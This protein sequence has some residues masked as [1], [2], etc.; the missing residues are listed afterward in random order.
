MWFDDVH[1][2]FPYADVVAV[3]ERARTL[4]LIDESHMPPQ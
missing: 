4:L 3:L 1:F 2:D